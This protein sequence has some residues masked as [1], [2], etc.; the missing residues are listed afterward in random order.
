MIH[1]EWALTSTLDRNVGDELK[2][3]VAMVY[4]KNDEW[5]IVSRYGGNK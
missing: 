4:A 3:W 2:E 1:P 5:S